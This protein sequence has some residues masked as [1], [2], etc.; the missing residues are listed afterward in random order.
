MHAGGVGLLLTQ[1]IKH[2]GGN[3]IST[4]RT[5]EKAELARKA[6][7]DDVFLY[8]EGVDITAKVKDL[9]NGEGVD[10]AYDGVGKD[11]FGASLASIKVKQLS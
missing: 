4:V 2:P 9:T 11:T 8:G 5:E 3:V 6:G 1:I 7:A 10:V